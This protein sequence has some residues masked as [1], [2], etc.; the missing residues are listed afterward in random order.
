MV[1]RYQYKTGMPPTAHNRHGRSID[2]AA[3]YAKIIVAWIARVHL[4]VRN[5]RVEEMDWER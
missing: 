4:F 2:P 1:E 3:Y 5:K